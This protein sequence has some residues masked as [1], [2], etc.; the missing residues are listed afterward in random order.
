MRYSAASA[1][2]LLIAILSSTAACESG[3]AIVNEGLGA[4]FEKPNRVAE[5]K[6]DKVQEFHIALVSSVSHHWVMPRSLA[7]KTKDLKC[8]VRVRLMPTGILAYMRIVQCS[9]NPVFDKS[10]VQAIKNAAPFPV[11]KDPALFYKVRE[12]EFTFIPPQEPT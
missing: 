4:S 9:N 5:P 11:P 7:D 1:H 6:L 3:P 10:V 2:I 8:V 12:I